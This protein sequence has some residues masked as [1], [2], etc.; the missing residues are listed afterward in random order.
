MQIEFEGLEE[1]FWF[2]GQSVEDLEKPFK[3]FF[4][5]NILWPAELTVSFSVRHAIVFNFN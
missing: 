1:V 4:V 3:T 2:I 5:G